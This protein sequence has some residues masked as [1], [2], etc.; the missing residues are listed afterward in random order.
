MAQQGLAGGG[1]F[2][3]APSRAGGSVSR[4]QPRPVLGRVGGVRAPRVVTAEERGL[5]CGSCMGQGLPWDRDARNGALC[6]TRAP[7]G[8][9]L[10]LLPLPRW[11]PPRPRH[12]P[13]R[14]LYNR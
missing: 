9:A 14:A 13:D 1:L 2:P 8:R 3:A 4:M 6:R 7:G 11:E 10:P 5:P 12:F